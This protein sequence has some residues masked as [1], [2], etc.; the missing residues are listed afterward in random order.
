MQEN[1]NL[2]DKAKVNVYELSEINSF[3][4]LAG[5]LLTITLSALNLGYVLSYL[6][7]SITTLFSTL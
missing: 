2:K 5:L 4:R 3:P 1:Q 6:S 7:L